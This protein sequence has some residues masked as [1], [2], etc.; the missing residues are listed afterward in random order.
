MPSGHYK[1]CQEGTT[2]C[3]YSGCRKVF[4]PAQP[5]Q[6]YCIPNHRKY[7][8]LRRKFYKLAMDYLKG[9]V[10]QEQAPA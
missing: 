7:A 8:H 4:K 1:E 3:A 5:H 10:E 6:R 2:V 9:M